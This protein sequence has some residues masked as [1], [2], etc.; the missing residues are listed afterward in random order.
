MPYARRNRKRTYRR[1]APKSEKRIRTVVKSELK[2]EIEL[3][4]YDRLSTG[5]EGS[6]ALTAINPTTSM[7]RGTGV[8]NYIGS[9]IKPISLEIRGQLIAVDSPANTMRMIIIQDKTT[10]S[11]GPTLGTLLSSIGPPIYAPFSK[12]FSDTYT[13]I[14][15]KV[16]LL[17]N[18]GSSSA[19]FVPYNFRYFIKGKRLRQIKFTTS[20]GAPDAGHIWICFVGDSA[21]SP[22]PAWGMITRLNYTDA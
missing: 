13:L 10:T 21:V 4:W 7:V 1:P 14:K 17:R 22:H 15:D 16:F 6:T 19:A 9:S 8:N 3:K 11:T 2:K 5:S 12:D 20:T 18:D